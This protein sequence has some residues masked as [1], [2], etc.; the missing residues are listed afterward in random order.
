MNN[1]VLGLAGIGITMIVVTIS[2]ASREMSWPDHK[3]TAAAVVV[4]KSPNLEMTQPY[5][6]PPN[7]HGGAGVV[8]VEERDCLLC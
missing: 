1:S 5:T 3:V 4:V 8:G 2:R 6:W 7:T